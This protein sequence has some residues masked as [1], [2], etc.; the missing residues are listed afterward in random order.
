MLYVRLIE[1]QIDVNI[2]FTFNYIVLLFVTYHFFLTRDL[3]NVSSFFFVFGSLIVKLFHIIV[4][5]NNFCNIV[6]FY[7]FRFK[8]SFK[9]RNRVGDS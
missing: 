9:T 6:F 1:I 8:M 5:T 2:V 4:E 3:N 7:K